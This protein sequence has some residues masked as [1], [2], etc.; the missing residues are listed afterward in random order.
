MMGS[1]VQ[2]FDFEKNCLVGVD[3]ADV[4]K[5]KIVQLLLLRMPRL[6][7]EHHLRYRRATIVFVF[8]R[9]VGETNMMLSQAAPLVLSERAGGLRL[10]VYRM[11][12]TR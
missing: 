2:T 11:Q 8:R 10:A 9:V 5:R 1:K 4:R 12:E 3:P 6:G 7:L